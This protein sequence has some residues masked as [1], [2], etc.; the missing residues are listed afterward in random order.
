[1][2][3]MQERM[4]SWDRHGWES[5]NYITI[6]KA[7][8]TLN[9]SGRVSRWLKAVQADPFD[10]CMCVCMCVCV[11]VFSSQE[12]ESW[13]KIQTNQGHW[14]WATLRQRTRK[15]YWVLELPL[16]LGWLLTSPSILWAPLGFFSV[17]FLFPLA[18]VLRDLEFLPP[19]WKHIN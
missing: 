10:A 12:F 14:N 9:L 19:A 7:H 18:F 5:E 13:A 15:L 17:S 16:T 4:L 6:S 3:I 11:C 8:L 1:M 2:W